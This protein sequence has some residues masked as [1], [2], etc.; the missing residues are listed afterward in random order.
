M[1]NM[2]IYDKY[3]FFHHNL[4]SLTWRNFE[5]TA[6]LEKINKADSYYIGP[7]T[8]LD[9]IITDVSPDNEELSAYKEA[10]INIF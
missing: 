6:T 1:P 5:E 7:V 9:T 8:E 3:I 4:K 10:G 2:F